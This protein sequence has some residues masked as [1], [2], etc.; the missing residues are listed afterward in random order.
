MEINSKSEEL[1][2]KFKC[3]EMCL[4]FASCYKYPGVLL[5]EI[6]DYAFNAKEP[7]NLQLEHLVY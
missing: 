5:N 1:F 3:G 6:L 7:A 4:N 2:H